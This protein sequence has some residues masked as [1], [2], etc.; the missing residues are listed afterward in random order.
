MERWL[1]EAEPAEPAARIRSGKRQ[2]WS[3]ACLVA[4]AL[5]ATWTLIRLWPDHH[6]WQGT[7]LPWLVGTAAILVGAALL[8]AIGR[9]EDQAPPSH[10]GLPSPPIPGRLEA[11]AFA[12]IAAL[13]V[14]LPSTALGPDSCVTSCPCMP[15]C[16]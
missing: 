9:P 11:S 8:G 13:A 12:L 14:F 5:L 15:R 10:E 6:R 2:K 1:P 16:L 4:A 3:L 7:V